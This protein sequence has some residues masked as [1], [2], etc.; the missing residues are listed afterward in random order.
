MECQRIVAV[1][2]NDMEIEGRELAARAI[3]M[4]NGI[5]VENE[6]GD[7]QRSSTL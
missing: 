3:L 7:D 6:L 2:M 1:E 4:N 5:T